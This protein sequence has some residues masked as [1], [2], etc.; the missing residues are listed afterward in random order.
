MLSSASRKE[1]GEFRHAKYNFL[2]ANALFKLRRFTEALNILSQE[3]EISKDK[4]GWEIGLRTLKIMTLVEMG[5]HSEAELSV[6]AL[7]EFFKYTDKK[8]RESENNATPISKR[9]RMILNLL[10]QAYRKGFMFATLNGKSEKNISILSNN[11]EQQWEPFTHEVIPFHEWFVGKMGKKKK[12][13]VAKKQVVR[14]D[15]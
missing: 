14:T 3:L 4:T 6:L 2:L 13:A 10:M 11:K 7:R 1:L 8:I 9:D 12:E 5:K 15:N